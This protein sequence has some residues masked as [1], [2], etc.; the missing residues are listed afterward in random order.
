MKLRLFTVYRSPDI[1]KFRKFV[2][3]SGG[4]W[5]GYVPVPILNTEKQLIHLRQNACIY[6]CEKELSMETCT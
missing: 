4:V 5:I 1:E 2:E 3:A 6:Y